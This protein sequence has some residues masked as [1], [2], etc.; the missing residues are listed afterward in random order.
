MK[1]ISMRLG[2]TNLVQLLLR[3]SL[4]IWKMLYMR[5]LKKNSGKYKKR[6]WVR[7]IYSEKKQRVE[8]KMTV[9]DLQLNDGLFLFEYF[10]M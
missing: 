5:L 4:L 10:R 9:K 6:F 7:K 2:S 3:R 1:K 8:L